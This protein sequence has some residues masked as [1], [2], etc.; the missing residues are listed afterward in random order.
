M[1]MC[2]FYS[3]AA[4]K[5]ITKLKIITLP[6]K[7]EFYQGADWTYGVWETSEE[8]AG[9]VVLVSSKKISFTHN[10][11][12]GIYPD[13]G[14]LDMRGLVV[15]VSYSDGR[16]ER[17]AYKETKGSNGFYRANICASPKNGKEYFVGTNTIEVYLKE[18]TSCFDSYKIEI[19]GESKPVSGAS[20]DV[21]SDKK[22]NSQ[23]AL[24]VLQHS[25][26]IITLSSEQKKA[27]DM[28]SDKK[29]NSSDALLILKKATK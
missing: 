14:M 19:L 21:N 2:S 6:E 11:G 26:G 10:P 29:I 12:G 9:K 27:A 20:G 25:V 18:N 23:D 17:I 16:K 8:K 22:V 3:F 15:E 4:S 1:G 13:R 5:K 7:T 24:M 28:N